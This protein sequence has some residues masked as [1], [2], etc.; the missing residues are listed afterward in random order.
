MN[1][2]AIHIFISLIFISCCFC[3]GNTVKFKDEHPLS[4][5]SIKDVRAGKVRGKGLNYLRKYTQR[6]LSAN[7]KDEL[8]GTVKKIRGEFGIPASL[9]KD[10][11][12][13]EFLRYSADHFRV[14]YLH[15]GIDADRR[16]LS[17]TYI[18]GGLRDLWIYHGDEEA[19]KKYLIIMKYALRNIDKLSDKQLRERIDERGLM[20]F[21]HPLMKSAALYYARIYEISGDEHYAKRACIILKRFGEV[22]DKWKLYYQRNPHNKKGRGEFVLNKKVPK[23]YSNYGLWGWWGNVH[24]LNNAKPLLDAYLLIK[25]SAYFKSLSEGDKKIIINDLLYKTVEK[26]LYL[27]FQPLH[28]QSM[29]RISG[30]IYF[31]KHLNQP[32]YIHIAV[33]W[34]NEMIHLAYR[35]DGLWFE[36]TA[37]YGISVSKK[38]IQ[39]VNELK[40][41]SDPLGYKN[42]IDGKRFDNF[43]P[44][45]KLEYNFEMIKNAFNKLALPDGRSIPLEDT[46]WDAKKQ[47][48][49]KAPKTAEPFLFGASGI[50]MLGFGKNERQVRLYLHWD[51]SAGHDHMD[52]LGIALWAENQEIC[53]ETGYRGVHEWNKSTAAHN[54]VMIDEKSQPGMR[55]RDYVE[56]KAN[57]IIYRYPHYKFGQLI[58][59]RSCYDDS[60]NLLLWDV[61]EK[62]IQLVEVDGKKA[63]K[64]SEGINKYQRTLVLVRNGKDSFYIVD[65]FRVKGGKIHDWML[66]GNLGKKYDIRLFDE[67]CKNIILKEKSGKIG[68]F[69]TNLKS[70]KGWNKDFLVEFVSSD[71]KTL[72]SI[73]CG[74]PGTELIVTEGPSIRLREEPAA[75]GK[76]G[77]SSVK[78]RYKINSKYFSVRRSGPKNVFIAVHESYKD[79]PKIESVEFLSMNDPVK[80]KVKLNGAEDIIESSDGRIK[81]SGRMK[82]VTFGSLNLKGKVFA[83]TSIDRGDKE[84]SF[85]VSENLH[86]KVESGELI[87]V[88]DGDQRRHPYIIE[89]LIPINGNKTKI[90]V[91]GE[92]GMLI[93]NKLMIMTYYPSWDIAGELTYLIPGKR[94]NQN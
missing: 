65:I 39:V 82:N 50:G 88:L 85:I 52:M 28:N 86:K 57:D 64:K 7:G 6:Q 49:G 48:F 13:L 17:F 73:V 70:Y 27:S 14:P 9:P 24:G 23:K 67:D 41:W 26:H 74:S 34:I 8:I 90:V 93:E 42:P 18:A 87:I 45:K 25:R 47:F 92:T 4:L 40:G 59:N 75:W 43:K 1:K 76:P 58:W 56:K 16:N 21:W 36:G 81:Y 35:R 11:K 84:N 44:D 61:S 62:D 79:K 55:N 12:L 83:L 2:N 91:K 20:N 89:K 77:Y 54:T 32:D 63:F 60:G 80:V 5:Y 53:S 33:R 31:G 29:N 68:K 10:H 71:K 94:K 15:L 19:R 51:D 46:I 66:H 72:R 69:M 37:S 22:L 38:I 3:E 30:M 78:T